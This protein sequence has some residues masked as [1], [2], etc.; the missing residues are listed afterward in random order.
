MYIFNL[1]YYSKLAY[2][3]SFH[4]I[5]IYNWYT[6]GSLNVLFI[7]HAVAIYVSSHVNIKE[8][9][10]RSVKER[11]DLAHKKTENLNTV[12]FWV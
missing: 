5:G 8:T 12:V 4:F 3:I 11:E 2:F 7:L 10:K 1:A 9:N 6:A